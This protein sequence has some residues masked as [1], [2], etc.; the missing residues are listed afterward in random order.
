M[1]Y[2][3]D[4][5]PNKVDVCVGAYRDNN[6]QPY[7]FDVVRKAQLDIANDKTM[8]KVSFLC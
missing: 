3:A 1:A 2:R 6:G 7:V 4:K 8:N 5:D